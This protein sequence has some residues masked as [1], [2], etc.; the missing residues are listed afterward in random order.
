MVIGNLSSKMNP[1]LWYILC[2]LIISIK[3]DEAIFIF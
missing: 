3:K 2:K 1:N